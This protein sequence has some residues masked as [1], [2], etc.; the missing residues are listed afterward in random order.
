MF[1]DS[2]TWT[3]SASQYVPSGQQTITFDMQAYTWKT[4]YSNWQNNQQV[5]SINSISK[6]GLMFYNAQQGSAYIDNVRKCLSGAPPPPP[7]PSNTPST[8]PPPPSPSNTP[9]TSPLPPPPPPS[10]PSTLLLY[11]FEGS[12]QQWGVDSKLKL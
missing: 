8:S 11:G 1:I 3:E 10:S 12:T 4:Q 7:S 9:S 6:I 2:N 5:Q